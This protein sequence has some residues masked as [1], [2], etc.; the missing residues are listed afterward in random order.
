[1]K[2]NANP[3]IIYHIIGYAFTSSVDECKNHFSKICVRDVSPQDVAKIIAVMC[4][5]H[6][7]LSDSTVNLPN[8]SVFWPSQKSIDKEGNGVGAK[9]NATWNAEVF[10]QTISEI[11]P[12]TNWKEVCFALDHADFVVNDRAA[13]VLLMTIVRLG[14]QASGA[15]QNFPAECLYRHWANVEGQL[16]L[17]TMILKNSDIYSF[18]DY[19]FT[20]VPID[21]FKS[22]PDTENKEI[23]SWKS[24]HLVEV[25]L[26]FAENGYNAQVLEL[27]KTPIQH[28]PDLL[29]MALLQINPPLTVIRQE[30]FSTLIPIF[31]GNHPNS[32]TILHHGWNSANLNPSLKHIIMHAMSEWYLRGE[33]DQTRLTRILDVAQDLKALSNLLNVRSFLFII[34]L[35]CLAS[36]REYLK[37]DK[38]LTDK[39]REHGEAFVQVIIKFLQRRCPQIMGS[40]LVDDPIPKLAQLPHETLS[41][42]LTCLQACHNNVQQDLADIIV[43]MAT[44]GNLI[45]NKQRSQQVQ[46]QVNPV[47]PHR[48]VMEQSFSSSSLGNHIFS[49][50]PND[51]LNALSSNLSG[52]NLGNQANGSFAFNLLG[53]MAPKS[54]SPS[55]ILQSQSASPFP[56]MSM[57]N[58]PN[59]GNLGR[60]AGAVLPNQPG[61][62]IN[63]SN[64]PALF[65]DMPQN[66]SKEVEDEANSYFQRI[67]NQPPH[68]TLA[69]D[70]VLDMLQ[71]FQE[72]QTRREY[73]VSLCMLKNLFEE[74]RFFPKYPD[75]ELQI[76]AQLFGG[77]IERSLVTSYVQLGLALRCV[78]DALREKHGTKMFIFGITALDR[79][80]TKLHSYQKYC[81]HIRSIPHFSEFPPHLIEY[82]EYGMQAQE[83]PI[84]AQVPV[85]GLPNVL[86]SP[87]LLFRSNSV[88]SNIT[89]NKNAA[90]ANPSAGLAPRNLKSIAN[91]TNINTLLTANVDRDEK[92]SLPPDTVQDK[93]AFI[94]NNLSQLNLQT[95]CD[96]LKEIINKDY[97]PWLSQYLVLKRA[98]IELNFHL[99]YSNFLDALKIP[100]IVKMV[101]EETFR[102]IRV[103][104]H[105][106]K[107]IENFS[108]RSLLKSLGHW[109]GMMTLARN[110]PILHI[111]L[112]LKLLLMEAYLKG[113][114]DL[115][116]VVPFVAKIVESCAKSK[117]FKPPNPWTMAIMNVLAE[118]HQEPELKLNLKFEIE[119]LCKTLSIDIH[120]LKPTLYLRD[121]ERA[122]IIEN[123]F[124]QLNPQPQKTKQM[125]H[126]P[127]QQVI[128]NQSVLDEPRESLSIGSNVAPS[129]SQSA[130]TSIANGPPEPRYN[131]MDI[132]IG[133]ISNL[134]QHIVLSPS[135]TILH[136][137]PQL[138]QFVKT[139]IERTITDWVTPVVDRSVR[140]AVNTCEQIIRKDFALEPDEN[141]MRTAAHYMVRNLTAGMAMITC[142]DQLLAS[143][144]GNI[145]TALAAS[146]TLPQPPELA[147]IAAGQLASDNTELACAF[148]QKTAIEK[149]IPEIEKRL[150]ND[151]ELRKVARQEGR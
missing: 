67:Y 44:N 25:L 113:Q 100:E 79:F 117:V 127:S 21:V 86:P 107:G 22:P 59:V 26:Y 9:E 118:L 148:I 51:A 30:L 20:G 60:L 46:Q 112:D 33:N 139:A 124:S 98:S 92:I 47:R 80:K 126:E 136:G 82:V 142:R 81:E 102:N 103:L 89:A 41:T 36:R 45:L 138:K 116:Y 120:S 42:I 58:I 145:K 88:T 1:M 34:D 73:Q 78:L 141:R 129:P 121:T 147:E 108:D 61:D 38:W 151:F 125:F 50:P 17:F 69:I 31:L 39:M 96:E 104:L 85:I 105:S 24:L 128:G 115:L 111:D 43:T 23:A 97:W 6:K 123:Q 49:A 122:Q 27:F 3:F 77:M 94:F 74:Y 32:A 56:V 65:P 140:I 10:V 64:N 62:K 18:S 71:R 2:A 53:N 28:C 114:Q 106:D 75:K 29:F 16:S 90:I 4:R 110:K 134:S 137:H 130:E 55:R 135:V 95:K 14:M 133:N 35:A 132:V 87:N 93:T 37:L 12:T 143:I 54:N 99:L 150:A 70:E 119:V 144:T 91:A 146:I 68:P 109:L 101:T 149:A 8:P 40:K 13:L 84:K 48:G 15:G 83:P 52:L 72:N 19:V 5:T 131:Y 63:M 76:T 57:P 11:A 7:S 66:P